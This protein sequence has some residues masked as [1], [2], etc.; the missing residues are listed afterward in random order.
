MTRFTR[1]LVAAAFVTAALAGIL[2]GITLV[3][4][5]AQPR[6]E[7]FEVERAGSVLSI[8]DLRTSACFIAIEGGGILQ[9]QCAL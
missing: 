7:R 9:V 8:R 5:R 4:L 3:D 2:S 6:R 1:L